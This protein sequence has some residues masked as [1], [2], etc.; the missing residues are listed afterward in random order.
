MNYVRIRSVHV[1]RTFTRD[2]GAITRCGRRIHPP[3][4]PLNSVPLD[5]K[6]CER[7]FVL[8]RSD[9]D[10]MATENDTVSDVGPEDDTV[11]G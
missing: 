9:E 2:G 3:V 6:T 8:S 7:C 1:L 10:R 11:P 5:E 4:D